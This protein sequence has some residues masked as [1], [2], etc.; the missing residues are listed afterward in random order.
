VTVG[1]HFHVAVHSQ[2]VVVLLVIN[3]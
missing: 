3:H 1:R 2:I